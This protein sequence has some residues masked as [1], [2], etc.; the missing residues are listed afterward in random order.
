M[1]W[2]DAEI[3]CTRI[4]CSEGYDAGRVWD[5]D[6]RVSRGLWDVIGVK[7]KDTIYVQVKLRRFENPRHVATSLARW[8]RRKINPPGRCEVWI[9]KPVGNGKCDIIRKPI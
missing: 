5:T 9:I 6:G 4:L 2:E 7:G 1:T 3:L 8:Y